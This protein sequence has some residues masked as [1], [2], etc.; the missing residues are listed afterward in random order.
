MPSRSFVFSFRFKL[1]SASLSG[2][3]HTGS[4]IFQTPNNEKYDRLLRYKFFGEKV[5]NVLGLPNNQWVYG[6]RLLAAFYQAGIRILDIS[7]EL[8]G[9]LYKQGREIGYFLPSLTFEFLGNTN[10]AI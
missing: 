9:D 6:D 8:L 5:C 3:N 4:I 2:S 10:S 1:L 7:G